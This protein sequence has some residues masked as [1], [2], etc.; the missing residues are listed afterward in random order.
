MPNL[1]RLAYGLGGLW[2][3]AGEGELGWGAVLPQVASHISAGWFGLIMGKGSKEEVEVARP[4]GVQAPGVLL[5]KA[6]QG[7]TPFKG[8][9]H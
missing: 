2:E 8:W 1:S 7:P 9:R 6:T 3:L 5:A 4:I